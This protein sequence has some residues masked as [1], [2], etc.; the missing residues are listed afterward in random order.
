[1]THLRRSMRQF[2]LTSSV[3]DDMIWMKRDERM[4]KRLTNTIIIHEVHIAMICHCSVKDG[5]IKTGRRRERRKTSLGLSVK[6]ASEWIFRAVCTCHGVMIVVY[7]KVEQRRASKEEEQTGVT[8][9]TDLRHGI[10]RGEV[11]SSVCGGHQENSSR[12]LRPVQKISL[13]PVAKVKKLELVGK[14]IFLGL[15]FLA[16]NI[17]MCCRLH[18]VKCRQLNAWLLRWRHVLSSQVKFEVAT[19]KLGY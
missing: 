8:I 19:T 7:C 2:F 3:C 12:Q 5:K 15:N 13:F 17:L 9:P 1:M 6:L 14:K 18:H 10:R 11:C 16:T 4:K